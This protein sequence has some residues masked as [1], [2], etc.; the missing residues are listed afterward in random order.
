MAGFKVWVCVTGEDSYHSNSVVLATQEEA[1]QYAEELACHWTLVD[2]WDIRPAD[3]PV[4]YRW[5]EAGLQRLGE[6]DDA[7]A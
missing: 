5:T 3:K 1:R 6:E 7:S 4:N 2:R